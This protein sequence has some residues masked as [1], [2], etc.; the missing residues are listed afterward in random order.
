VQA[1]QS[2][3]SRTS[4]VLRGTWVVETLLGEK[5][6]KP[7]KNVPQL[8]DQEGLDNLTTRQL[9][10]RHVSDAS[11]AA[12]HARIDPYGFAFENFDAIGRFR[13][14]EAPGRPVDTKAKLR[15]G[16][17][18]TGVD[19]L[20]EYLLAKKQPEFV[21]LFCQRLLGYALGRST[22]LSDTAVIDTMAAAVQADGGR[23]SGA[24]GVIL[25]SP[26]FL[27]VRG[28]DAEYID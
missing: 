6:P 12:C 16:T 27:M 22:T 25:E 2:G 14:Q 4:P 8:P 15:D 23:V 13:T 9:V 10:E 11:C 1:K 24:I 7:P 21:R 26:Q 18:F 20:R 28:K 5:L 19:G 17:E 3:A